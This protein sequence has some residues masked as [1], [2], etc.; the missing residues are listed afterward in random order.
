[1]EVGTNLACYVGV[2]NVKLDRELKQ[3]VID[4]RDG[5]SKEVWELVYRNSD[6]VDNPKKEEYD[7]STE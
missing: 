3:I 5:F 4:P 1:M 2:V 7:K 6:L